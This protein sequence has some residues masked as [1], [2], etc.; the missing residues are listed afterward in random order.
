MKKPSK[1][2]PLL[3]AVSLCLSLLPST[4]FSADTGHSVTITHE[5]LDSL[6]SLLTEAGAT[7]YNG[8]W[9]TGNIDDSID[10][11]YGFNQYYGKITDQRVLEKVIVNGIEQ[12]IPDKNATNT[13]SEIPGI[14]SGTVSI[15]GANMQNRLLLNFKQI[16]PTGDVDIVF[17]WKPLATNPKFALVTDQQS[18]FGNTETPTF[19]ENTDAGSIYRLTATPTEYGYGL[20]YWEYRTEKAGNDFT[21]DYTIAEDSYYQSTYTATIEQDTEYKAVFAPQFFRTISAHLSEYN[22]S[23]ATFVERGYIYGNI[24]ALGAKTQIREGQPATLNLAVHNNDHIVL[25]EKARGENYNSHLNGLPI[26]DLTLDVYAGEG[27]D[28]EKLLWSHDFND[29]MEVIERGNFGLQLAIPETPYTEKITVVF[30]TGGPGQDYNVVDTVTL[31][32]SDSMYNDPQGTDRGEALAAFAEDYEGYIA[33]TNYADSTYLKWKPLLEHAYQVERNKIVFA[34]GAEG[35]ASA[36]AAAKQELKDI[37]DDK[38]IRGVDYI[39]IVASIENVLP[40]TLVRLPAGAYNIDAIAAAMEK[41]Y[42]EGNATGTWYVD[43][44]GGF[45]NYI[46]VDR[47]KVKSGIIDTC[48]GYVGGATYGVNGFF[49]NVGTLQWRMLDGEV[50]KWAG[51]ISGYTGKGGARD[52]DAVDLTFPARGEVRGAWALGVLRDA[53]TDAQ[54]LANGVSTASDEE[55]KAKY[56]GLADEM[57]WRLPPD[58]TD[59]AKV[60]AALA[61]CDALTNESPEDDIIAAREAYNAIPDTFWNAAYAKYLFQNYEPYRAAYDKLVAAENAAGITEP[62]PDVTYAEALG[63]VL[64]YIGANRPEPAFGDEWAVLALARGDAT[65]PAGY[66]EGYYSRIV[67]AVAE[68]VA[69]T[70]VPGRLD[71]SKSTENSRLILALSALGKDAKNV[72]GHDL[73]APFADMAWVTKQG[74]NGAIYALIALDAL[75]DTASET[76]ATRD[77]LIKYILDAALLGGGW[78][79]EGSVADVDI[80]AMTLQALAPY[81]LKAE[82][83]DPVIAVVNAALDWLKT[84]QDDATGGFLGYNKT[85]SA[86]STAQVVTALSA[87][88]IPLAQEEYGWTKAGGWN[89][90]TALLSHYNAAGWFGEDSSSTYNGMATEQAAYA[91]VAYDRFVNGKTRLYD[92]SDAKPLAPG[93][94]YADPETGITIE[95]GEGVLPDN[96]KF[97]IAP[98]TSETDTDAYT[99]ARDVLKDIGTN[100][101]VYNISLFN[102]DNV[103]V[104]Q[105]STTVKISLPIPAGM[106]AARLDVYRIDGDGSRLLLTSEVGGGMLTFYTDHFS[107]YAIVERAVASSTSYTP[108]PIPQPTPLTSLATL[109]IKAA[110][111][112]WNGKKIAS[113]F[114]LTAGG[115]RL[116]AG[117]DYTVASTGAN[118]NIGADTVKITGNGAYT[119]TS[120][121]KFKIVPKAVNLTSAK[122][123]KNSMSIKWAKAPSAEKITRYEV[124]WKAKGAKNWSS[125]KPVSA[126]KATYTAKKLAKGKKYDVQARA[127]KTVKGAKYYSAWSAAKPS[128]KVK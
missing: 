42:P 83:G 106:D 7:M 80:T 113:G 33:K 15:Q 100:L 40:N 35:I 115:K 96:A 37:V 121:V 30:T 29:T 108:A 76:Q 70:G 103:K 22:S 2:L 55:L 73:A 65:L 28:K 25:D 110:D 92:M 39:G 71:G 34:D 84:K 97:V 49:C 112:V 3:L 62:L 43:M 123:G 86:C 94:V 44:T 117:K 14:T 107:L 46:G 77:G 69:A 52:G 32:I 122:A 61:A 111:K 56:P 109:T 54:L 114:V 23:D 21:G 78:N 93:D 102:S 125:P 119:G 124:R 101:A 48:K 74:L 17:L 67:A 4:A 64:G 26:L 18:S 105:L 118:K 16:H 41:E 72:G 1:L 87:L 24:N 98:V 31:D 79:L 126:A 85:L 120:T 59:D 9:P 36:L 60:I 63:S 57:T 58:F 68:K 90:V 75:P 116:S 11:I 50:T 5:N 99:E 82:E 45:I 95:A 20:D 6:D 51:S 53:Y 81:Y 89:P 19:V 10:Y 91:L 66:Y 128:A 13:F 127:Y 104:E 12:S 47:T 88:N 8:A 38:K 27:A